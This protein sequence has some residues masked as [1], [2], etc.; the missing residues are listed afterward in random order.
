MTGWLV[1]WCVNINKEN[2]QL[3]QPRSQKGKLSPPPTRAELKRKKKD[4]LLLPGKRLANEKLSH[5]ANEK[6]LYFELSAPP[7]A[8][9]T[10]ASS[11]HLQKSSPL[12]AV[13]GLAYSS[14]QLQNPNCNSLLT[15]E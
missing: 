1:G 11:P 6:P 5:S 15:L 13:R 8:T 3:K 12:F 4:L 9:P 14:P 10:L 7:M 2:P